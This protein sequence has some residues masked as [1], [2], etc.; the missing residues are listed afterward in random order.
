MLSTVQ[1][2]TV[3]RDVLFWITASQFAALQL[4]GYKPHA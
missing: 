3:H 2:Y 4:S 1:L